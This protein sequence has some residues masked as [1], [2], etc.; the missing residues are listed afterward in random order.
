MKSIHSQIGLRK[1]CGLFGKTRQA[2][3]DTTWRL[4]NDK[5]QEAIIIDLVKTIRKQ[6]PRL[7]GVK[8]YSQIKG[9]LAELGIK[10]GRDALFDLLRKYD[11]LIRYKRRYV[12]TT[13]SNH[14]YKKWSNM[15]VGLE[16]KEP[17]QLWVSDITY[18]R[19]ENRFIYL[20]LITDAYSKKIMGFHLS[21]SLSAKGCIIALQMALRNRCYAQKELIHH[22]D[23]GIQ[24]C[25]EQYV[26]ILLSHKI[27]ISMTQ[28]GDPYENA[29]AERVN[30][31]LKT[32]LGLDITFKNYHFAL[33]P[34][35]KSIH[36]YNKLRPHLSCDMLT[37]E[38]AHLKSGSLTKHWKNYWN[39]KKHNSTTDVST[40]NYK[41]EKE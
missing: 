32:E 35:T 5:M 25:C 27:K 17:E 7:G 20:F 13:Q 40:I 21:Q 34:L 1:L 18:L 16:I 12:A 39:K 26:A 10:M 3:Y 36:A 33:E 15:I 6:L 2:W 22:S 11:L 30:G 41:T 8:L 4:D 29:I 24:Y 23:R 38:Q 31:I 9:Q 28:N 19:T 37:P 14:P